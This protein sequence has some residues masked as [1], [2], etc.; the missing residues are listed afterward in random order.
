MRRLAGCKQYLEDVLTV[1]DKQQ[2]HWA[3]YSFREDNWD[4]MDYELGAAKVPW[5]YW[6]AIERVSLIRW[7]A[8][9]RL[10]SSRFAGGWR[11]NIRF[12]I[13]CNISVAGIYTHS[14]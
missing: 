12:E 7:R 4:G 6:Q 3:F 8:R 2:L 14:C 1:L 11:H 10:S 5:R 9:L 13:Y